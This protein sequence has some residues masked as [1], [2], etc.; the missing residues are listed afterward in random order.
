MLKN[1]NIFLIA[2]YLLILS[3]PVFAGSLNSGL[4]HYINEDHTF[5]RQKSKH[6]NQSFSKHKLK[7]HRKWHHKT[8][9]TNKII[10]P[11]YVYFPHY[12]L[13]GI[14]EQKN[15][16]ITIINDKK[17][18]QIESSVN[19]GKTFSPPLIVDLED[20]APQKSAKDLKKSKKQENVILIY[21]TEIIETKIS[22]D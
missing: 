14:E 19:K 10:F 9:G 20:V 5:I 21:G 2:F 18:E 17:D 8:R 15:V 7:F 1:I 12:A 6:T 3:F 16:Y 22:L 13:N 4:N 11:Y